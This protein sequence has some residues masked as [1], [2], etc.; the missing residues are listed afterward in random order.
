MPFRTQ[1]P[2]QLAEA[3]VTSQLPSRRN[4]QDEITTIIIHQLIYKLHQN[5]QRRQI[6][7]KL[8]YTVSLDR[9]NMRE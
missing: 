4:T 3:F 9:S 8:K 1:A 6:Y 5:A 7:V 2:I